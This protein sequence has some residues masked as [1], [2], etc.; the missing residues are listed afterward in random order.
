MP[1]A[2]NECS[3]CFFRRPQSFSFGERKERFTLPSLSFLGVVPSF[4]YSVVTMKAL[5][6]PT[7]S[8][9]GILL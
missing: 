9:K 1:D 7:Q 3:V 6:L 5:T 8:S 4:S 2:S